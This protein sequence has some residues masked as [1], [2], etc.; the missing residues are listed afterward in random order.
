MVGGWPTLL[1]LHLPY[2]NL[3]MIS[4]EQVA[5]EL[6]PRFCG[7]PTLRR[8][9]EGWDGF[10]LPPFEASQYLSRL[11]GRLRWAAIRHPFSSQNE[12]VGDN[13]CDQKSCDAICFWAASVLFPPERPNKPIARSRNDHHQRKYPVVSS[14]LS[15]PKITIQCALKIN[16]AAA[17]HANPLR[18]ERDPRNATHGEARIKTS[19]VIALMVERTA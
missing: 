8:L 16:A 3:R 14:D 9:C 4:L 12:M 13:S 10:A 19:V 7:C 1:S 2:R 18:S 5:W 6:S 17:A 11:G 15:D